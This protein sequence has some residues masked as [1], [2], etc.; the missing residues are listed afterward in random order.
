M[1]T[2]SDVVAG[3]STV[4]EL[5]RVTPV[6]S[7]RWLSEL[8][9]APVWLKCENLQRAGSFKV[10][11]AYLR[12][13]RMTD[14]ERAR[15]VVTASAGNHAQGM[16]VAAQAL[17]VRATVFMP[18]GAPIPKVTATR[19]YGADVRFVGSTI[20]EAM[21]AARAFVEETGTVLV[22][23]FDHPDIV[24]GQGT[25]ALEI[26][27]QVP[28]V[29]TIVVCT[30]GGGL[31]AGISAV[32]AEF[33]PHVRLVG[34][35]A[36]GAAAYPPSLAAGQPL[37]L[38]SMQTMADGIAVGRPGAVPFELITAHHVEI[39]T[40][41]EQS[42]SRALLQC[43]ERSKLLVEP[44]G[45]AAMAAILDD[46]TSFKGP[47]VA[48]AS[49]GNIDPLLLMQ[50]MRQ[51]L[52]SAGRYLSLTVRV[53]DRPGAL[54][55]LL[56]EIASVGANVIDVEHRRIDADLRLGD[57]EILLHV[58]TRGSEHRDEVVEHLRQRE[59]PVTIG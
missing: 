20:D 19:G 14:E 11:G 26:L 40:T 8:V 28:D 51:G 31:L 9:Q 43:L 46:P 54:A 32:L 57:V 22:H 44:A 36:E 15:G 35:Q 13:S 17:G 4:A 56:T 47:V 3:R 2:G 6:R 37:L 18:V 21:I 39:R 25:V 33:A 53:P 27:E 7:A 38:P 23:P 34:V 59:Y 49:G 5:A 10:R 58:E 48:T 55:T 42:M 1:I 50:V 24:T 30:G 41:S 52:A 29:Q 16:S 12:L 45:A